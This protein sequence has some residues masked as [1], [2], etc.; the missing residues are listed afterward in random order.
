[1]RKNY[2]LVVARVS[3]DIQKLIKMSNDK[4]Y[5]DL[6]SHRVV[7]RFYIKRCN[8]CQQFGHYEKECT[9]ELHCGF[10]KQHHKSSD[11]N[12]TE[13]DYELRPYF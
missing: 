13:G 7:D 4:I 6:V 12:V 2:F 8:K 3:E 11:C 9:H 1:M 5:M 10:C